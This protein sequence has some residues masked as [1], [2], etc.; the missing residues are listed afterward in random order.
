ML[1]TRRKP[2]V[3]AVPV[4]VLTMIATLATVLLISG[5]ALA[6]PGI[7]IS[8][9]YPGVS[10]KPGETARLSVSVASSDGA[11][12]VVDVSVKSAPQDWK[13]SLFAGGYR[14][15]QVL[16]QGNEAQFLELEFTVPEKAVGERHQIVLEARSGADVSTLPIDVRLSMVGASTKLVTDYP[17]LQGPSG[18][19]FRFR[20]TLSNDAATEQSYSL[21]VAAPEGWGIKLTPSYSDQEIASL[22]LKPGASQGLEL[23]AKP[24]AKAEAGEYPLI[25]KAMSSR[26]S[27][28]VELKVTITG[29][30]E[31]EVTTPGE[32]LNASVVSG[33]DNYVTIVVK[34]TG[35]SPL[36]NLRLFSGKPTNWSVTFK[37]ETIDNIPPGESKQVEA[38]IKPDPRAVAG[39]YIVGVGVE[40]DQVYTRSDLRVTVKTATTWGIVG[41]LVVAGVV[42]WIL[43]LFKRYG[44][45]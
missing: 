19:E 29:K 25:I 28:Q 21:L 23:S 13:P 5:D 7:I 8:T 4:A 10:V 44:R 16:V 31:A 39:D 45:R 33:R 38:V 24:P 14:V 9:P 40:N 36:R 15:H 30:Y 22:S 34:N 18:A 43:D 42:L 41:I 11:R 6:S 3:G 12:R 20:L 27:A 26:G 32:R 2:M 35:S 1:D 37:P 17:A